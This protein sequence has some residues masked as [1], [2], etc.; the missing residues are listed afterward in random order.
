VSTIIQ[1]ITAQKIFNIRGEE[2]IEINVKTENGF[3]R[4]SAPSGASRGKGEVVPYPEGGVDQAIERVRELVEPQLAGVDA[5]GQEKVDLLL[6]QID[7]TQDFRKIGGNTSYAVSLATAEAAASSLGRPLFTQLGGQLTSELPHPLGN[8]IGGGKHARGKSPDIQE[9][10]VLP[11][12]VNTFLDAAKANILVHQRVGSYLLKKDKTFT[13]GRGDEGAWAPNLRNE[14]ALEIVTKAC[15]EVSD[16]TGIKCRVGLD[17]AASSLWNLKKECYVYPRDKVDKD[18]GEQL[19]FVLDL[20]RKY[21]LAYVEDPLHEEDFENFAELTKKVK[22]CLICGDD[23]FVTNKER[24][25]YGIEK[26]VANAIIIKG[27][28]VGTLT[29]AWETTILG[30]RAEYVT[31]MSHR[32]GETTE[33]HIAHLAVAFRCPIIKAGVVEGARIA[34]INELIRIERIL[35]ERAKM[36]I[37]PL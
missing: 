30:Q 18:S 8:V 13:G 5:Q 24:L 31:V 21:K 34:I 12:K 4:A 33:A 20:V 32:S 7:G 19:E 1:S 26:G 35:E 2:T 14:D 3:G 28:Q 16:E 10:L 6:N 17:M 25:A 15:E 37:T 29:D 11:V 9:F 27:N 23:L 36:A 22:K